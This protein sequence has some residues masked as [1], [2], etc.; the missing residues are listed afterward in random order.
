MKV[1][2]ADKFE[3]EGMDGLKAA[4]CDIDF[5]P[6]LTVDN[7]AETVASVNPEILIVRSTK[8]QA[9]TLEAAK[10]LKLIIRAGAGF[11]TIDTQK[12]RALGITV[13]N[14]PGMN[15][16][17]VAE[18]ALGHILAFDRRIPDQVA[19]LRKGIWNKKGYSKFGRGLVGRT[20]GLIGVGRIGTMVAERA[21]AFEMKIFYHDIVP[22]MKLDKCDNVKKVSMEEV[23]AK[24]DFISLHVAATEATRNLINEKTL[25]LMQK[26]AVL[27]NT[28]RGSVVDQDALVKALKNNSI[29]GAVLD[30]YADEP[31]ATDNT[32]ANDLLQLP[33]FYGT[34]HVGASTEQAQLAVAE[35]TVRIVKYYQ[36]TGDFINSVN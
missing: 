16:A 28:C 27:I 31:A 4:K 13:S 30:V 36:E 24:S 12:A 35:E 23:L 5:Q 20:L 15:S 26:H 18:L 10:S 21:M 7:L 2:I 34:H 25:G 19:D 11:D 3:Q 6:D 29:G 32:I 9:D 17:A 1:L 8:V 22:C 14:C 33:N